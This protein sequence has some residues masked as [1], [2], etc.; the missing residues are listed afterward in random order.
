MIGYYRRLKRGEG[1][2]EALRQVQ[3]E[4]IKSKE[5]AHPYFWAGFIESGDWKPLDGKESPNP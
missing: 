2:G 4:M 3:L 1:R 5:H